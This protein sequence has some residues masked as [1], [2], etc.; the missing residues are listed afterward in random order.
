MPA[1]PTALIFSSNHEFGCRNGA[2][3]LSH[4]L[5]VASLS[6][7]LYTGCARASQ[8]HELDTFLQ[9][10]GWDDQREVGFLFTT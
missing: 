3:W 9:P 2:W 1:P 4:Y 6:P 8:H 5:P 10:F 7:I